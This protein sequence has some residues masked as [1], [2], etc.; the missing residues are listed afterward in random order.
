MTRIW[1][2]KR[3]RIQQRKGSWF[4]IQRKTRTSIQQKKRFRNRR[5]WTWIQRK[6]RI[7]FQRKTR[8]HI[9]QKTRTLIRQKAV[10]TKNKETDP[11]KT[12]IRIKQKTRNW[13]QRKTRIQ[14]QREKRSETNKRRGPESNKRQRSRCDDKDPKDK[15]LKCTHQ[16][17][18]GQ[19]QDKY[20]KMYNLEWMGRFEK[21]CWKS[22]ESK[23]WI[24][25]QGR[26]S[27]KCRSGSDKANKCYFILQAQPQ[28]RIR[29]YKFTNN[30]LDINKSSAQV[31]VFFSGLYIIHASY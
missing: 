7:Q 12:R 10:P 4:L 8:I 23:A 30:Y 18:I 29:K 14:I 5:R 11:T 20:L 21:P 13:I 2:N 28:V 15:D 6:A 19:P 1:S 25:A 16:D 17:L 22:L 9:Q 26:S 31:E 24:I 27:S 3:I